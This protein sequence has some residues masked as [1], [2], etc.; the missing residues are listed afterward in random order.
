MS[1][2][3]GDVGVGFSFPF[4]K[5]AQGQRE[6]F[7]PTGQLS[8]IEL[9]REYVDAKCPDPAGPGKRADWPSELEK[10]GVNEAGPRIK[11]FRVED[12]SDC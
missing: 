3:G 11:G 10:M 1:V 2:G 5:V 4:P 9:K 12:N 7:D 8:I 6:P